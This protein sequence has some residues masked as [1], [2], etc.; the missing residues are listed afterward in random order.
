MISYSYPNYI[1]EE[2]NGPRYQHGP[3]PPDGEAEP[4]VEEVSVHEVQG[5]AH[6]A[7][8][9]RH[10]LRLPPGQHGAVLQAVEGQGLRDGEQ[11]EHQ[12][13]QAPGDQDVLLKHRPQE[14]VGRPEPQ[15]VSRNH[16]QEHLN[17]LDYL[18]YNRIKLFT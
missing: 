9:P 13:D 3:G 18:T 11:G 2:A 17:G 8:H 5:P 7:H 1:Y 6:A 14:V 10:Q 15:V 16:R 4:V 12:R